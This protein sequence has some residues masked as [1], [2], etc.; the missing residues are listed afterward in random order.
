MQRLMIGLFLGVMG[1]LLWVVEV[2]RRG[3]EQDRATGHLWPKPDGTGRGLIQ[4]R[5][6]GEVW[7]HPS[8]ID[9]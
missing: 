7:D 8:A 6:F 2:A 4:P 1:A 9:R 3:A 5:S